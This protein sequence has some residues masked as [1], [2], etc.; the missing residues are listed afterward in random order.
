M[1]AWV[2]VGLGGGEGSHSTYCKFL[3]SP[4]ILP[5]AVDLRVVLEHSYSSADIALSMIK[6]FKY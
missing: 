1:G 6:L 3:E 4:L 2:G 5:N